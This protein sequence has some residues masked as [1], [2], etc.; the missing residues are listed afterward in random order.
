MTLYCVWN[1]KTYSIDR[2]IKSNQIKVVNMLFKLNHIYYSFRII[3]KCVSSELIHCIINFDVTSYF[4]LFSQFNYVCYIECIAC[5]NQSSY[6]K[7]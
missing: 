6:F 4:R 1:A 3:I 2:Y 5:L 7:F